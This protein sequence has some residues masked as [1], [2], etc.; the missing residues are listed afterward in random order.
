MNETKE[1]EE[2]HIHSCDDKKN[3]WGYGEWVEECDLVHFLYKG[4]FCEVKRIAIKE[5]YT[6]ELHMFG[7]HLCGYVK[8]PLELRI[9]EK[10]L[11]LNFDANVDIT[12][13]ELDE[14]GE[15]WIGF[16][17]AHLND[18]LPSMEKLN[19][20][21]PCLIELKKRQEE[22]MEKLGIKPSGFF[23]KTYKNIN[24][25]I[26]KCKSLVDQ[27]IEGKLKDD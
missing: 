2:I 23:D 16:D 5:P 14:K 25:C 3:W 12:F 19:N 13:N 22:R 10:G 24:F 11:D 9:H 15:N 7:G 27:I 8:I 21:L 18:I 26:Q 4:Y 17:C 20:T 6:K 1:L